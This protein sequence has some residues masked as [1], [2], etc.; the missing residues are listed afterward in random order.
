MGFVK[1]PQELSQLA[2]RKIVFYNAEMIFAV[3]LTKPEVVKR[4]L[5][6]PLKPAGV[7]L[8][9]AFIG[10]YPSTS[11]GPAYNEAALFLM[12]EYDG[13]VGNYC[14]AMPV[15]GDMAMAGGRETFGFPK[16]IAQQILL[17]KDGHEYH[18]LVERNG[19]RFFKLD[20]KPDDRSVDAGFRSL[21][22]A[23][24]TQESG[25]A[26]Y[27][28]KF[29]HAPDGVL[30]DYPPRLI[31][32]YTVFQPRIFEWGHAQV[33]LLPSA[34]DPWDEVEVVNMI[35]GLR[36]V[37]DNTMLG[38]VVLAEVDPQQFL[39]YAFAKWDD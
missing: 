32:Q 31:R 18:G 15:T 6:P 25:S 22:Q 13:I 2:Q 19:V 33:R 26:T 20:F 3:W 30:F 24:L 4:L 27:L 23:S 34:C 17:S 7:P 39:P 37:G 28:F 21:I 1:T 12:A 36:M 10:D 8:A 9:S 29:F 38:G 5:P 11:F 14:L 35:G 16:K